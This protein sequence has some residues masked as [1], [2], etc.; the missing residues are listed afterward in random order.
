MRVPIAGAPDQQATIQF[1]AAGP[2]LGWVAAM[3]LSALSRLACAASHDSHPVKSLAVPCFFPS[4][5][6]RF[7]PW[8]DTPGDTGD[9]AYLL[10]E[11]GHVESNET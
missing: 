6:L 11:L 2:L 3:Q 9:S 10:E 4:V 8:G 1:Y 7:P 5:G